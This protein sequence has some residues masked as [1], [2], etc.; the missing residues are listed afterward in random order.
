[1]NAQKLFNYR[2]IV[3]A[4]AALGGIY[5]SLRFAAECSEG[6]KKGLLFCTEVLVPS[7]YL[8][9]ALS[10][11]LVKSGVM[12]TLSKP[13]AGVSR[14]IFRL[15]QEGFTVLLLSMMGGYPVGARCAAA[16][17]EDGRLSAEEAEATAQIAVCAGPGFLLNYVGA[18]LLNNRRAGMILLA[19]ETLG[20]LI[21]GVIIGRTRPS[22]PVRRQRTVNP[23]GG[24]LLITAVSEASKATF[25]L[26]GMVVLCAAGVEVIA[27]VSPSDVITDLCS[28]AVEITTGCHRMCGRYPLYLI[29]F[30]VGFGGI[31]V[32]LQI[33]AGLGGLSIKKSLFFLYRIIQ[34]I[35][36]AALTYTLMLFFP[37]EQ[38]VFSSTDAPL[39][40]AK[41]ATLAGSAAL[42]LLSLCFL[43]SVHDTKIRR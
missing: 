32:H 40:F 34:G 14:G 38:S 23:T 16:L 39:T 42:I 36:T 28:A 21:T 35:I 5:L 27:A 3:K 29:A 24:N 18:A 30:F 15:P 13:F 37:M 41:S 6:I 10:S 11:L 8:F 2:N 7:L 19:A 31:S 17:Y 1:M 20:M 33:F 12:V 26:C 9:M 4:A 22:P 43:G 25:H